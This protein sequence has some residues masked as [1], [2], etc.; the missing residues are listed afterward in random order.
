MLSHLSVSLFVAHTWPIR[1]SVERTQPK[2][3]IEYIL[4]AKW[5]SENEAKTV[6]P[7]TEISGG[8][9]FDRRNES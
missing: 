8:I 5:K 7:K 3:N 6:K 1:K 4:K 9:V 2:S